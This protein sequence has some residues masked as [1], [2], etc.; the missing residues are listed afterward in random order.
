MSLVELTVSR[1]RGAVHINAAIYRRGTVGVSDCSK[2]HHA[3]LPRLE[4]AFPD[5]ELY[6]EVASPGI[7]RTI[8]DASEFPIYVGRG[9]RCYRHDT[10]DWSAGIIENADENRVVLRS[11]AGLVELP[12]GIVAK[13]K[14]DYSQEV[15]D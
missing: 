1:H 5:Q 12:Y 6:V 3:I 10:S 11:A 14:L 8:K 4:L 13:A 9:V 2:V 7:D 15:E